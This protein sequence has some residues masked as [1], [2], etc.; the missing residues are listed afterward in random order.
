MSVPVEYELLE[1]GNNRVYYQPKKH[2]QNANKENWRPIKKIGDCDYS[3]I[4]ICTSSN[5]KKIDQ[6]ELY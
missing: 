5:M 6:K 3:Y 2:I 4:E 1:G